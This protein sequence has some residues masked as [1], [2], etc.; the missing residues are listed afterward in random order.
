MIIV[1]IG[2]NKPA[3]EEVN[4]IEFF[5][6]G[7]KYTI[8]PEIPEGFK[9]HRNDGEKIALHPCVRSEIVVS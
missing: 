6:N 2:K 7:V 8:T 4:R 5:Q 1:R 9:V 3:S